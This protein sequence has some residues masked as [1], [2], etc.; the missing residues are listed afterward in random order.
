MFFK[1]KTHKRLNHSCEE[2]FDLLE[3]IY[4]NKRKHALRQ[5]HIKGI[6]N[7]GGKKG[8]RDRGNLCKDTET[9]EAMDDSGI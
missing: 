5:K 1:H 2:R 4:E 6:P 7:P 3:K 9:K 8:I